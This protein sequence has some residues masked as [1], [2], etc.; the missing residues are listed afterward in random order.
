MKRKRILKLPSLFDMV[1]QLFASRKQKNYD[2]VSPVHASVATISYSIKEFVDTFVE[3]YTSLA[4]NKGLVFVGMLA[5]KDVTIVGN[6]KCINEVVHKLLTNAIRNTSKG[7][8]VLNIEYVNGKLVICVA[9]SGTG[10]TEGDVTGRDFSD[11]RQ[12]I[13][14]LGGTIIVFSDGGKGCKV[15]VKV[16]MKIAYV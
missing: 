4:E 3:T 12:I 5:G 8:V 1:K 14:S 7:F 6:C 2:I 10:V 9:D 16:P 15:I 11:V 13:A